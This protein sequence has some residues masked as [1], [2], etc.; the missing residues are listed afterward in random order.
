MDKDKYNEMV[1]MLKNRNRRGT[2]TTHKDWFESQCKR[3]GLPFEDTVQKLKSQCFIKKLSRNKPFPV[4][5]LI[6]W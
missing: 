6:T 3:L 5:I 1:T 4:C 2:N